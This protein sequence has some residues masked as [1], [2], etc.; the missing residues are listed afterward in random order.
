M[1]KNLLSVGFFTLLS[2][3]SGF[4][5]DVVLGAVL[6]A[7]IL[8]DAFYIAFRLPNH[9]RTIFGEG[10][11]NAAYVPSYSRVLE[12]DGKEE[13]KHFSSQIFTLLLAS[14]I[15]LLAL[16]WTFTPQ[17]IELL[18]P[19]FDADPEKMRL[20]VTMTQITFPYLLFITLVTLH[21]GTL[22]ANGRFAA[23]AFAPVMMNVVMVAFLAVAFLFPNAGVAASY[24]ITVSGVVQLAMMMVAA[25]RAG[26]LERLARPRLDAHVK[27]F[28]GALGPAVIGSAGVQIALFADTIIGS[29]LP[30]GGVSSI[31]YA[32]RIYQL[33]IGVIG[34]A[35]GTV[36]LPEMSRR[37]AAGDPGAA[38]HAQN[39]TMA[40]TLALGAPFF[41][42][43]LAIP[44][45]IMRGVFMRGRFTAEAASASAAVLAAYGIGILAIVLIRSAVASFQAHGDTRT[46]M[47]VSLI[48]VAINVALKIVLF[49]PYGAVGLA[50]ATAVGAWINFGLLCALAIREGSMR[51]DATLAKVG[52]AVTAASALLLGVAIFG[53]AP[54]ARLAEA[55]GHFVTETHLLLLTGAGSV[56]YA[57]ALLLGLRGLGVRLARR[58]GSAAEAPA[59]AA[60]TTPLSDA[61][62]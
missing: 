5:R 23:A 43:F 13:A 33:P 22:N 52:L 34:I 41:I 32:D 50:T 19:G 18:A 36:L 30:T 6:G 46:P 55:V 49:R 60:R 4:L 12:T 1:Y 8:A 59:D 24:G 29:M 38:Y 21:S 14:Q 15:V 44:E 20:A 16:A 17:L 37:L 42:A 57:L 45:L 56:V 53:D 39:R 47:L 48:S 61:A 2:R 31:Y 54:T 7:G 11:F 25:R 40:L 10:A 35:A 58:N 27:Q 9:F 28:F 51:P 26:V 3:G 62:R